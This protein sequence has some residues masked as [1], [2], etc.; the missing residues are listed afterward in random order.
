MMIVYF[1]YYSY[2]M[3]IIFF[4]YINLDIQIIMETPN[5]QYNDVYR[6]AV[7]TQRIY[8]YIHDAL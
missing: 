5:F 3:N 2:E 1:Y 8:I 4:S 6:N 7:F